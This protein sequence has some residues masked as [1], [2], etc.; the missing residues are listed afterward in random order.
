MTI[1]GKGELMKGRGF[2]AWYTGQTLHYN[3]AVW[4]FYRRQWKHH[5]L[6]FKRNTS[7]E[8]VSIL[9]VT[10]QMMIQTDKISIIFDFWCLITF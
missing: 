5:Q 6:E 10:E 2:S 8:F 9:I 4:L 1:Y 7:N 3:I